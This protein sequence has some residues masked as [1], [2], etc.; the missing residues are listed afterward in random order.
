MAYLLVR[1][2]GSDAENVAIQNAEQVDAAENPHA[3]AMGKLVIAAIR[4]IQGM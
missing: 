3:K 4:E 2:H 1:R